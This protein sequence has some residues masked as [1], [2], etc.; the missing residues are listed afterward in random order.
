MMNAIDEQFFKR[1]K[2]TEEEFKY[3]FN[4]IKKCQDI[5]DSKFKV[6]DNGK[7]EIL[8]LHLK[9]INEELIDLTGTVYNGNENRCINGNI[10]VRPK[11]IIVE[12]NVERLMVTENKKYSTLDSFKIK[13]DGIIR[14]SFYNC[15]EYAKEEIKEKLR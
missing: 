12:M 13:D 11:H 5:S 9:K 3:Y 14:N 1:E 4:L 10:H 6:N 8:E 7:C 15:E 2:M